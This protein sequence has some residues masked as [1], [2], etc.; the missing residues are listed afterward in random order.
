MFNRSKFLKCKVYIMYFWY[1]KIK[2]H[3]KTLKEQ[4]LSMTFNPNNKP[5]KCSSYFFFQ[6]PSKYPPKR[7]MW[8]Y[9]P[10]RDLSLWHAAHLWMCWLM[11]KEMSPLSLVLTP[12]ESIKGRFWCTSGIRTAHSEEL[13]FNVCG[14]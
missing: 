12:L 2:N 10:Q 1:T 7:G 3:Y 4:V 11:V 9:L 5:P 14:T 8:F 6:S 13:F